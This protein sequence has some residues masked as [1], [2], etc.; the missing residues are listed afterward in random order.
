MTS[1]TPFDW[2]DIHEDYFVSLIDGRRSALLMRH[3]RAHGY[4]SASYRAPFGLP[5]DY[6]MTPASYGPYRADLSHR[7]DFTQR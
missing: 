4:T 5:D 6:A 1:D 7:I 2:R 3:I